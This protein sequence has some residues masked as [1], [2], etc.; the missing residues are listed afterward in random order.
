[1]NQGCIKRYL[2]MGE[3]VNEGE[4]LSDQIKIKV[5]CLPIKRKPIQNKEI[6][7][8]PIGV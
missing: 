4:R 8:Y 3:N 5:Y 2:T 6:I 1:M 7:Q